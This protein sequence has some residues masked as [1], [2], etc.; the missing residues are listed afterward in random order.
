MA[1]LSKVIGLG[2]KC[3]ENKILYWLMVVSLIIETIAFL[4]HYSEKNFR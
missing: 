4:Q 3:K 2:K 1:M